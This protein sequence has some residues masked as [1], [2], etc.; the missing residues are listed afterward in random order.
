VFGIAV[1]KVWREVEGTLSSLPAERTS[2]V[3]TASDDELAARRRRRQT[4]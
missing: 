3:A 4:G 2:G 1:G